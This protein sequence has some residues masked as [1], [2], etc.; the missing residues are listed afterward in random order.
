ME[1]CIWLIGKDVHFQ[2]N[3]LMNSWDLHLIQQIE[4][5]DLEKVGVMLGV[6]T[7]GGTVGIDVLTEFLVENTIKAFQTYGS[8]QMWWLRNY[9]K[10]A[11]HI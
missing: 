1:E 8:T 7:N 2:G 6:M 4:Y 10:S 11:E 5:T 3:F 9:I